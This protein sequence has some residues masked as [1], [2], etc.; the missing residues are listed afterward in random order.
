MI[1][2]PGR[3]FDVLL[4]IT[5]RADLISTQPLSKWVPR[6][7]FL[8]VKQPECKYG[9]FLQTSP[10]FKGCMELY[11]DIF[12]SYH[13]VRASIFSHILFSSFMRIRMVGPADRMYEP[14][15]TNNIGMDKHHI[16]QSPGRSREIRV[17]YYNGF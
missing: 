11:F 17:K 8:S 14:R 9:Q 4:A 16:K 5:W 3:I 7:L 12:Y 6:A 1:S 10:E 2:I 13:A 15:N